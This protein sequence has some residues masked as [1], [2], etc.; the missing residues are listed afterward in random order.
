MAVEELAGVFADGNF[1]LLLL[2]C[3]F[4][5]QTTD[6]P[7]LFSDDVPH[8]LQNKRGQLTIDDYVIDKQGV[9]AIIA[10]FS[11]VLI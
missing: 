5:T 11:I 7:F 6:V 2:F 10:D 9:P 1:Y 8:W 3:Y 4:C